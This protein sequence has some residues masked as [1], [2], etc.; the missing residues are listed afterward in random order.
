MYKRLLP[1]LA[2]LSLGACVDDEMLITGCEPVGD[3]LISVPDF[4]RNP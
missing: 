3:R 1:I 4:G 2:L